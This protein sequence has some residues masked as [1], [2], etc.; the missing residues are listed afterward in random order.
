MGLMDKR[1]S[2]RVTEAYLRERGSD[3]SR[4]VACQERQRDVEIAYAR[5]SSRRPELRGTSASA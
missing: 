3:G 2:R 1:A 4:G 5:G